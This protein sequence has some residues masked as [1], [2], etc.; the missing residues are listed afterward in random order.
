MLYQLGCYAGGTLLR[1]AK[2]IA[3]NNAGARVLVVCCE[4]MVNAYRG[5]TESHMDILV[6][7]AI[8]GDG[9]AALI[10]GSDPD[11]TIERPLFQIMSA[12]QTIIPDT[13]DRVGGRF[14]EVGLIYYLSKDLCHTVADNISKCVVEACKPLGI[15]D[16]NSLFWMVH[17]GGPNILDWI[18]KRLSLDTDKLKASR[19]VLREYGNMWSTS[20]LFVIDEMRKKSVAEGS[21][22]T[23]EGLEWGIVLGFGPGVTVETV[24]LRS[25]PLVEH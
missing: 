12:S 13:H 6:G 1:V 18:E 21:G 3:E 5:P 22:T 10:V 15:T 14:R 4:V 7:H 19:H 17:T 8:F 20:V 25:V 23:G 16:W 24:V 9:A 2:D 11:P